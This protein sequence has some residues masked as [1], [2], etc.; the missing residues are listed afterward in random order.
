MLIYSF[1]IYVWPKSLLSEIN[2][3]L[4]NFAW[5]GCVSV[6]KHST[7]SWSKICRPVEE[8]GFGLKTLANINSG[9]LLKL[10]WELLRAKVF[11][12]SK[13]VLHHVSSSIW[14]GLKHYVSSVLL[15]C[16]WHLGDGER[17]NFWTDSWIDKPV[18]NYL[19][20]PENLHIKLKAKVK[21]FI[22]DG[23]WII[24][25]SL[26]NRS[27]EM[28]N[29]ISAMVIPFNPVLDELVWTKSSSVS[30]SLKEA[31][32]FLRTRHPCIPWG[33]LIWRNSVPPSKS[34]LL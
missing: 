12:N 8:G 32:S 27:A 10:C 31:Y 23:K 13:P 18:V 14:A 4:R 33:K 19:Q 29:D 7:V 9:S 2:K 34:F 25:Q 1:H 6:R 3:W 26:L 28:R 30:L 15:N 24:P 5:S 22:H 21:D 17:I 20:I 11:H 16:K